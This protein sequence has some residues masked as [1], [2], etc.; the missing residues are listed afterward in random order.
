M[1]TF[2]YE[3]RIGA[4]KNDLPNQFFQDLGMNLKKIRS[5][6]YKRTFKAMQTHSFIGSGFVPNLKKRTTEISNYLWGSGW[7]KGYDCLR[8]AQT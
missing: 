1:S 7:G 3:Q 4:Y 6:T 2:L 5:P 8:G